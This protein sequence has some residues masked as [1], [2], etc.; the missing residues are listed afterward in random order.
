[1]LKE[2]IAL[3]RKWWSSLPDKKKW[4]DLVTAALTVPVL[5]TVIL[6]NMNKL[7]D[8]KA[9]NVKDDN[10]SPTIEVVIKGGL[11][12]G[13]NAALSDKAQSSP[14]TGVEPTPVCSLEPQPFEIISPEEGEKTDTDPVCISLEPQGEGFCP[15]KWAFRVNGSSYSTYTNDPI[16]LYNM[17]EGSVKLEVRAKSDVSGREKTY[18]RNFSYQTAKNNLSVTL[19]LP[20]SLTP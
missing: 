16:C 5:I 14:A 1:M 2:K 19:T 13:T 3:L 11:E 20:P 9:Q 7:Q 10:A 18:I 4:L 17:A 8:E 6:F 12:N 15:T